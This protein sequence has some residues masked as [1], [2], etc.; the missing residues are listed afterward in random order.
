MR[1]LA[2]SSLNRIGPLPDTPAVAETYPGVDINEWAGL[3]APAGTPEPIV[4]GRSGGPRR[5]GAPGGAATA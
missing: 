3:Y 2:V 4:E 5:A 1:A